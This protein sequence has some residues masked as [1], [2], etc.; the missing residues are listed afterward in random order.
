MNALL[1]SLLTIMV[2]ILCTST[3]VYAGLPTANSQQE[4][5]AVSQAPAIS[6][7]S[8]Q[9]NSTHATNAG[10]PDPSQDPDPGS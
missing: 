3:S 6:T 5:G 1:K 7:K 9:I 2:S 8:P 10:E 4:P